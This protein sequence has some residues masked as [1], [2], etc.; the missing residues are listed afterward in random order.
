MPKLTDHVPSEGTILF[1]REM[2]AYGIV[3]EIIASR[4]GITLPTLNSMYKDEIRHASA[5][6]MA[7]IS[8]S[9]VRAALNPKG[10]QPAVTAGIYL[11]KVLSRK[12]ADLGSIDGPWDDGFGG[13]KES[14]KVALPPPRINVLPDNGRGP[15]K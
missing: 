8:N 4:L 14:A 5:E 3:P 2:T 6:L 12:L 15:K 1:V 9:L 7:Q 13:T 10:G 11:T